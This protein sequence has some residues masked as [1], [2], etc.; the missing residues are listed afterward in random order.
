MSRDLS[1][2]AQRAKAEAPQER[3]ETASHLSLFFP[4][5]NADK[6]PTQTGTANGLPSAETGADPTTVWYVYFLRLRNDDVYVGSTNDLR[7]RLNVNA[8]GLV[9]STRRLLPAT[10][11]SYV[12]VRDQNTARSLERYFKSDSGKA[13]ANKRFWPRT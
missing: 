6:C 3:R 1:A 8:N 12:A 11:A 2:E 13:F 9:V 4:P 7:V 5:N 10:L